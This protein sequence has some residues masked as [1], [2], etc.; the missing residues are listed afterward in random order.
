MDF[1]SLWAYLLF[2]CVAMVLFGIYISKAIRRFKAEEYFVFGTD[3]FTGAIIT[4]L[5]FQYLLMGH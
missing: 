4:V 3:L 5:Y 1:N 2:T